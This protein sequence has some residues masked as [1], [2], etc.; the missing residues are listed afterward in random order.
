MAVKTHNGYLCGYCGKLYNDMAK[1]DSCRDSHELIYVPFTHA[2][3][4]NLLHFIQT[5]DDKFLTE[6][7]MGTLQTYLRGN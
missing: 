7:L 4:N 1:A 2:D 6:H 3:L 5:K